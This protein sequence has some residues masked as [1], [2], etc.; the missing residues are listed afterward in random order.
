MT[1]L[2]FIMRFII[3][4][5]TCILDI[6]IFS[7]GFLVISIIVTIFYLLLFKFVL[8]LAWLLTATLWIW[9]L[10]IIV[11]WLQMGWTKAY[12]CRLSTN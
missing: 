6:L 1:E 9:P 12:S 4:L 8:L 5:T 7:M 10:L 2:N 3:N 11:V